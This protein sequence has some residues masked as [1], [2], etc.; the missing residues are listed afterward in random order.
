MIEGNVLKFGYGDIAVG[1]SPLKQVITFQQFKPPANCGEIIDTENVEFT[2]DVL[3][4]HLRDLKECIRFVAMLDWVKSGKG[5]TFGFNNLM[6]D[7]ANYNE[8]SIKVCMVRAY[9][10]MEEYLMCIAC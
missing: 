6:F 3:E 7:F 8:K 1:A 10:A 9:D 4:M 2:S 5:H